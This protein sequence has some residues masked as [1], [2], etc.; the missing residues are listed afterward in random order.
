ML[1]ETVSL[2]LELLCNGV[3]FSKDFLEYFQIR[4]DHIEKRRAY[5]TGDSIILNHG[6][7]TPQEI[8][9]DGQIIAAANYNPYSSMEIEL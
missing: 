1:A 6:T 4:T 5:G 8:I 3:S 7:R 2:K 9:L